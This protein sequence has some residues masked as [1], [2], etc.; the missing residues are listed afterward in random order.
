MNQKWPKSDLFR[1]KTDSKHF[2]WKF[3]KVLVRISWNF[4]CK[5]EIAFWCTFYQKISKTFQYFKVWIKSGLKVTF[6][7]KTDSKYFSWKF[8]KVLVR[9]GWNY[10]CKS[11]IAL[12]CTFDQKI[13]RTFQY[14]KVWIKSGLKWLF[15][16]KTDSKH[17]SWKFQKVLVRIS[18]NFVCKS[19]IAFWCTFDQKISKTFQYFK[20][21]IKSG[22]KVTFSA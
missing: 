15:R 13:S 19:E 5:S 18:W 8:Q 12:W 22:L 2:S 6:R 1:P 10:V 4:V 20:V 3:Q 17:F 21:W 14:F 7:P 11:E 16:P 9:I